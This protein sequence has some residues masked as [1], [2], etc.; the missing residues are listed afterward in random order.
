[1]DRVLRETLAAA[2]PDAPLEAA[3]LE[4][5]LQ[6]AR[7]HGNADLSLQPVAV[8]LVEAVLWTRFRAVSGRGDLWQSLAV[9]I[10]ATLWE[11]P[12]S[13][14]RLQVLWSRLT[15]AAR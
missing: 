1:M 5:L 8:E 7:R 4:A 3:E 15:E 12:T 2:D 9:R 6:V 10:A 13:R 14:G 11:D